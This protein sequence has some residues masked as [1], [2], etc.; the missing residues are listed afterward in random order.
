LQRDLE[1]IMA[2]EGDEEELTWAGCESEWRVAIS[3]I[4]SNQNSGNT[5]FRINS[6][7]VFYS[8]KLDA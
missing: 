5:K 8:L 6:G 3:R 7:G 4:T 2:E 1:L